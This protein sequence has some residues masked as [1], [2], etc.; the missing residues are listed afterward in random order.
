M[1]VQARS[2]GS[3]QLNDRVNT[4]YRYEVPPGTDILIDEQKARQGGD[5]AVLAVDQEKAV[6][7]VHMWWKDA[8]GKN[9]WDFLAA[10]RANAGQ[11]FV[12][13]DGFKY[14]AC[15]APSKEIAPSK[16]I[17]IG[18]NPVKR[19]Y[20]LTLNLHSLHTARSSV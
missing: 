3:L 9:Y 17:V 13:G 5:I 19:L 4:F 7:T 20:D 8:A 14:D 11:P 16:V 12:M 18:T 2:F 15:W 10:L 6:I 1:T